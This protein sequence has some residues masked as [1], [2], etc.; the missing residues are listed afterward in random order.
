MK[1]ITIKATY[2]HKVQT[3]AGGYV[4]PWSAP[5]DIKVTRLDYEQVRTFNGEQAAI[6]LFNH[7]FGIHLLSK[8]EAERL[9]D[10]LN[11]VLED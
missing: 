4:N 1:H 3:N 7:D 2:H 6:R 10:F 9:R 11:E 8:P 5:R